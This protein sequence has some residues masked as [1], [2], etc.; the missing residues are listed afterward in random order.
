MLV[1]LVQVN[2]E[3]WIDQQ[4]VRSFAGRP[5]KARH[6]LAGKAPKFD[7]E[8]VEIVWVSSQQ[9]AVDRAWKPLTGLLSADSLLSRTISVPAPV[10]WAPH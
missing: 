5:V 9:P 8:L 6:P 10:L 4:C 1:V 3:Y 7:I 2:A